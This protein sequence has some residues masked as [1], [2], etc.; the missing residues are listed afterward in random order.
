[1][2]SSAVRLSCHQA[3]SGVV[4]YAATRAGMEH[5]AAWLLG[6]IVSPGAL[7]LTTRGKKWRKKVFTIRIA[8]SKA[9]K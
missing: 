3:H 4:G 1:M 7:L 5:W 8:T 2:L 6:P 9:C